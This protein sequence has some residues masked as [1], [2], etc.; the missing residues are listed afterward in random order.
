MHHADGKGEFVSHAPCPAC[1]SKDNLAIYTDHEYCFGCGHHAQQG[2]DGEVK[3]MSTRGKLVDVEY[4]PLAKRRLKEETCRKWGYGVGDFNGQRVQVASYRDSTGKIVGQK[5]RFPNKDFRIL[6]D[7]TAIPKML[8]GAHLWAEGGKMIVVTEGELDALSVSQA[9]NLKWPCVSIP[10]GASSAAK[11]VAENLEYLESFGQV[12][13]MFDMDD[14]GQAAAKLCAELLAPG[15]AKIA[16]LPRKDASEMLVEG[17]AGDIVSAIFNANPYRPDGIVYGEDLW[18][19]IRT[20]ES[21]VSTPYPWTGLNNLVHGI[22]SGELVVLTS[23]TG[24]GK[25]SVCRELAYHAMTNG[26]TVGY[27]AL[28]ESVVRSS[29]GLVGIALNRPVHLDHIFADTPEE[30]LKRGFDATLASGRMVFYDHFGSMENDR[31][32]GK[33]RQMVKGCGCST[34]FLDH[35]SIVVSA[36]EGGDERRRIDGACTKLRQLVEELG[37]SLF[38]VSHLRR[39]E[40][41]A[42]EEGGKTSINLLRGSAAIA[43]LADIVIGLERNQQG[44]R[45]NT[46]TVRVLKNRY[47]GET[48]GSYVA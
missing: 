24:I 11:A 10:N 21:M 28:E 18:E 33:I 17:L 44:E 2:N 48:G 43:Q 23:G 41:K 1:G 4:Q 32:I 40:G 38:L 34:I 37:I 26:S 45:A 6:G 20:R 35:L 47:S 27:I 29:L 42:L 15:K 12:V 16:R 3:K 46:T 22:R 19:K 8:Y 36:I 5:I 39:G 30:E 13:F 7:S 31:L 25:S 9:Q 14:P